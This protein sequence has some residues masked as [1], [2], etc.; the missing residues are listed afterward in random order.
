[1]A[2]TTLKLSAQSGWPLRFK[3]CYGKLSC[4]TDHA[5]SMC[6]MGQDMPGCGDWMKNLVS[7]AVGGDFVILAVARDTRP[8]FGDCIGRLW[9]HTP[10]MFKAITC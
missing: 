7:A 2:N 4:Q 5:E 6:G 9:R 8:V 10:S 3:L 1:L